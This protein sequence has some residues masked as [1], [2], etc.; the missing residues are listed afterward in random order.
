MKKTF[1]ELAVFARAI[2]REIRNAR[3]EREWSQ[4]QL[5]AVVD[6]D[7]GTIGNF[8][9]GRVNPSLLMFVRLAEALGVRPHKLLENAVFDFERRTSAQLGAVM[10]FSESYVK[11]QLVK[12]AKGKTAKQVRGTLPKPA[13]KAQAPK[14]KPTAK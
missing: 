13:K 7:R 11:A 4:E 2:G 10:G 8:E 6:V 14:R 9:T 1:P 3:D 5:A 12:Y